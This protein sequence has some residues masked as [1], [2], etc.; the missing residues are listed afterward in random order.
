MNVPEGPRPWPTLPEEGGVLLR[1]DGTMI[2][3]LAQPSCSAALC[4]PIP[5]LAGDDSVAISNFVPDVICEV[6]PSPDA[7]RGLAEALGPDEHDRPQR[8][9]DLKH[10]T[11]FVRMKTVPKGHHL[12]LY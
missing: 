2:L 1:V 9:E 12:T 8:P 5:P 6:S 7:L 4:T 3:W 11:T 10:R